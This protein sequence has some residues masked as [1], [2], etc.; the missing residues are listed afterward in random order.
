MPVIADVDIS[1]PDLVLTPTIRAVTD[2]TIKVVS[3]SSTDPETRLF[4]FLVTGES[5]DRFEEALTD[6]PTVDDWHHQTTF[7]RSRIYQLSYA[8]DVKL[9]SPK[10]SE[11]GGLM[12]E[13]AGT[14]GGWNVQL[15]FPSRGELSD[16]YDYCSREGI[17]LSVNHIYGESAVS[18]TRAVGV[19]GPQREALLTALE[20]GYFE[21]PR[22]VS[23]DELAG[24]LDISSTAASGRLRR[25]IANL[26]ETTLTEQ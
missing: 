10:T 3:D 26:V 9:I 25:G 13:A 14:D 6:D 23:L 17:E 4:S 1:H 8:R 20:H 18:G 12:L 11:V 22:D 7:E 19:T 5:F 16:L 15:Q 2:V 21:Q 24:E